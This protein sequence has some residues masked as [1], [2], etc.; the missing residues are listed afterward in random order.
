MHNEYKSEVVRVEPTIRL[1]HV[2][3]YSC[4]YPCRPLTSDIVVNKVWDETIEIN[5]NVQ[6][7][8]VSRMRCAYLLYLTNIHMREN[9]LNTTQI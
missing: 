3:I 4:V 9:Y 7:E 8:D 1:V 2:Q 5:C 6:V